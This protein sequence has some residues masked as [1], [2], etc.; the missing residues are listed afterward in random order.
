M[1]CGD[2]VVAKEEERSSG[3]VFPAMKKV[4]T[5]ACPFQV[6]D[7]DARHCLSSGEAVL[8]RYCD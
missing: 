6:P 7:Y 3:T 5:I 2:V 1:L 8:R 4:Q